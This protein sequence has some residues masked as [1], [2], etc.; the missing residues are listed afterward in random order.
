[1]YA[2]N[3]SQ[4]QRYA[5][6]V[7]STPTETV[8]FVNDTNSDES[9]RYTLEYYNYYHSLRPPDPRLP[10][11]LTW[12]HTSSSHGEQVAEPDPSGYHASPPMVASEHEEK[13]DQGTSQQEQ[14]QRH[15]NG[16]RNVQKYEPKQKHSNGQNH[17]K[18][19]RMKSHQQKNGHMSHAQMHYQYQNSH[20]QRTHATVGYENY[21]S[22]Q[23]SPDHF[24]TQH[25]MYLPPHLAVCTPRRQSLTKLSI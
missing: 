23:T 12:D 3:K 16:E 9:Y 7:T 24:T 6:H 8:K 19:N 4:F 21:I 10:V 2:R 17:Y 15:D 20:P 11:P 5:S 18:N 1:M 14:P 25:S 22:L 13:V